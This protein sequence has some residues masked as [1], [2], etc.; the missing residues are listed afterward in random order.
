MNNMKLVNFSSPVNASNYIADAGD[1]KGIGL[2]SM[3]YDSGT[4]RVSLINADDSIR[5]E[6]NGIDIPNPE[7]ATDEEIAEAVRLAIVATN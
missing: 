4:A 5:P 1:V 7:T 3:N 6:V 2:R